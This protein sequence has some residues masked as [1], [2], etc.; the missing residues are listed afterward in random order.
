MEGVVGLLL[1][2]VRRTGRVEKTVPGG[3]VYGLNEKKRVEEAKSTN[4][5]TFIIEANAAA[6]ANER[7]CGE[8]PTLALIVMGSS[9]LCHYFFAQVYCPRQYGR[10]QP[11]HFDNI[12]EN[13]RASQ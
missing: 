7:V 8:C 2:W 4:N 9:K 11:L 10:T 13:H 5:L 6:G 12:D 3:Y 1:P